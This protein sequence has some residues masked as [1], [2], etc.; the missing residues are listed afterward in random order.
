MLE[1]SKIEIVV[2]AFIPVVFAITVHE[3]SHGWVAKMLGDPTAMLEGRLTLNPLKHIDLI[4][5]IILPLLLV[6][7]S[8]P[9]LGWAKPVP[10]TWENLKRPK[11]DIGLVAAAGPFSNLLMAIFWA[12]MMKIGLEI[13]PKYSY[14]GVPLIYMGFAG[15]YAN[16]ILMLLNL[17]PLLPLDGGRVL[18]SL[19]PPHW[20][21]K[22]S[23]LEPFGLVI[24]LILL[25]SQLL[26][27]IL[28]KP[29]LLYLWVIGSTFD[30]YSQIMFLVRFFFS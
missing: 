3:V 17:L 6:F 26:G 9:A 11:R 24:L 7:F 22:Y 18:T 28:T 13:A 10:I 12:I 20:A 14:F 30:I 8:L 19:L 16:G 21:K 25:F 23:Q 5:T 27:F 2:L 4:G 1:L 15:I 29:F